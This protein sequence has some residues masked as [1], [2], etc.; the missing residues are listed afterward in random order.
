MFEIADGA[1]NTWISYSQSKLSSNCVQDR[2][3]KPRPL[4]RYQTSLV[5]LFLS[6]VLLQG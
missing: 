4:C 1:N 3:E 5:T 6:T 2:T